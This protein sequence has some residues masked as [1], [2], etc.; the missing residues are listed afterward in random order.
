MAGE[1]GGASPVSAASV[2]AGTAA[3]SFGSPGFAAKPGVAAMR[4]DTGAAAERVSAE[5]GPVE[6]K[7]KTV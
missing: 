2:P 5:T 1:G 4:E 7:W 3:G 6:T